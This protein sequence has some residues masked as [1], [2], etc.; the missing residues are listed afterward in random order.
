MSQK[1]F[2]ATVAGEAEFFHDF[3]LF[4]LGNDGAVKVG[5][6]TIGITLEFLKTL[7]ILEPF[8]GE[9]FTTIHT[10]Y[11]NNHLIVGRGLR[12]D[13]RSNLPFNH[14]KHADMSST[15]FS[16]GVTSQMGSKARADRIDTDIQ[17]LKVAAGEILTLKRTIE[18]QTAQIEALEAALTK[19]LDTIETM[20]GELQKVTPLN[21]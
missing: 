12:Q 14:Q 7:L 21:I 3:G 8:I 10:A 11:G 2:A 6:L 9:H 13:P 5:A 15:L 17:R 19:R 20:I 1:D 16:R 18:T 4:S